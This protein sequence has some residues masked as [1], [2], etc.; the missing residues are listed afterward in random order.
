MAIFFRKKMGTKRIKK[1]EINLFIA[2]G[3]LAAAVLMFFGVCLAWFVSNETVQTRQTELMVADKKIKDAM[4]TTYSVVG[5]TEVP[6]SDTKYD[7]AMPLRPST[8]LPIYDPEGIEYTGIY[9]KA[10]FLDFSFTATASFDLEIQ[11]DAAEGFSHD[12]FNNYISNCISF[13][14]VNSYNP[15]TGEVRADSLS[16]YS[17][18]DL[19]LVT[20]T[21]NY[22]QKFKNLSVLRTRVETGQRHLYIIMTYNVSVLEFIY[23]QGMYMLE[24]VADDEILSTSYQN[25]LKFIIKEA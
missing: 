8:E 13:Y 15:E 11:V 12:I 19:N 25:D 4:L 14:R 23:M 17:F 21:D 6:G 10:L 7:L 18:V 22:N 20:G 9:K 2:C 16:P 24:D 1:A 3:A 5:I